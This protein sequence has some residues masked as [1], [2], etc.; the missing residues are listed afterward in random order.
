MLV[1]TYRAKNDMWLI[2]TYTFL[3]VLLTLVVLDKKQY[4]WTFTDT[5]IAC[6]VF[7][8]LITSYLTDPI[9]GVWCGALSI[10]IAGI[11]NLIGIVKQK[12]KGILFLTIF[13]FFCGSLITVV[14]LHGIQAA[15]KEYIYPCIA[16][17]YWFFAFVLGIIS[18]ILHAKK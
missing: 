16:L 4:K 2:G 8:C 7:A 12:P 6:V 3:T 5:V 18:S 13:L 14:H 9:T 17:A 15:Q 1:N 11:P 10:S